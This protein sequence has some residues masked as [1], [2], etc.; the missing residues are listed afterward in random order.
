MPRILFEQIRRPQH[1]LSE[2]LQNADDAKAT[3]ASVDIKGDIFEFA[4]DGEDFTKEN[5]ESLCSFAYSSKSMLHTI[6]FRGVGFKSTFGLGDDV[7]IYTPS[8]SVRFNHER[9][10]EPEWVTSSPYADNLTH[11]R[12]ANIEQY[13]QKELEENL[14]EWSS[15]PVSLLFFRNIKALH[16]NGQKIQWR[17]L[18]NGPVPH[19]EWKTHEGNKV[20]V[21]RSEKMD[22]PPDVLDDIRK[23]RNISDFKNAAFPPCEVEVLLG[24]NKGHLYAILLAGI[25]SGLPFACN[26]PFIQTPDRSELKHPQESLTN[27]WLLERIGEL[28]AQ[29]ML[30]WLNK[31]D[32][33]LDERSGAYGL[34]PSTTQ[35]NNSAAGKCG[36]FIRDAFRKHTDGSN[37]LLVE[38]G[39]LAPGCIAVPEEILDAWAPEQASML[40]DKEQRPILYHK[41][42]PDDQKKILDSYAVDEIDRTKILQV[43]SEKKPPKPTIPDGIRTLWAYLGP[44]VPP[45]SRRKLNIVPVQGGKILHAA[46]EVVRIDEESPCSGDDWKFLSKHLRVM[47]KDWQLFLKEYSRSI[48]P[49]SAPVGNTGK[50]YDVLRLIC[51]DSASP[52]YKIMNGAA[53]R[54]SQSNA[55]LSDWVW[56]AQIAAKLKTRIDNIQFVTQDQKRRQA[57][58]ETILF[59]NG[60]ELESLLPT[61]QRLLRLLHRDYSKFTACSRKE[62][63]DWIES[64]HAGIRTFSK[65]E[66]NDE[67]VYGKHEIE[68]MALDRG[69]RANFS[70]PFKTEQFT[71]VDH[72]FD[73]A[74]WRHWERLA[75]DDGRVWFKIV[76]RMLASPAAYKN[77]I[78]ICQ[79][80]T[81]RKTEPV[82]VEKAIPPAWAMRLRK[83]R[84][85]P[86][87]R[88]ELRKPSELWTR[89]AENL[90]GGELFVDKDLDNENTRPLLELLGV[91]KAPTDPDSY[92]NRLRKLSESK[93]PP[94]PEAKE[95][96]KSLDQMLALPETEQHIM[97]AFHRESLVLDKDLNWRMVSAEIYLHQDESDPDALAIHPLISGLKMWGKMGMVDRPTADLAIEWVKSLQPRQFSTEEVQRIKKLLKKYPVRIWNECNHW[98]NLE[99]EWTPVKNLKYALTMHSLVP[100]RHL[101]AEIKRE[102]AYLQQLPKE[103]SENLPFSNLSRLDTKVEDRLDSDHVIVGKSVEKEWL[104]TI[105]AGLQL[106]N[107]DSAEDAE[108][109]HSLAKHLA[110]SK[111]QEVEQPLVVP[112]IDGRR[113]GKGRKVD[114]IW[115][116]KSDTIYVRR[117]PLSNLASL[118]PK[119]IGKVFDHRDIQYALH[120]G[121]ERSPQDIREYLES[122]FEL[123]DVVRPKM[124]PN[125][126]TDPVSNLVHSSPTGTGPRPPDRQ[127]DGPGYNESGAERKRVE[128]KGME[129]VMASEKKRVR[130]QKLG[131]KIEDV[132]SRKCGYDI[133]SPDRC[134]EVKSFKTTGSPSLTENEWNYAKNHGSECWLYIVENVFG[135]G[136]L[137]DKIIRIPDP[138][139]LPV[140]SVKT[141]TL[142]YKIRNWTDVRN[143]A[144]QH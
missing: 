14:K 106:V 128:L 124:N 126:G 107:L 11:I 96:Y 104:R 83:Y 137:E 51:L 47:D 39:S 31:Q 85:L 71:W 12:V 48:S 80:S 17:Y 35:G 105:G 123:S 2:L 121:F 74:H 98:L 56:F 27:R 44:D 117:L 140:D 73:E 114:V 67:Q 66:K 100:Y 36:D 23:E 16:I 33:S 21:V 81:T 4:H 30:A 20:L 18:R 37:M 59:D 82:S 102:T 7:E 55:G 19:S 3:E 57:N 90:G 94:I 38:D 58:K 68:Q 88:G 84:C 91:R 78:E 133:K 64:G 131:G 134:I 110:A 139:N 46:D 138:Q 24:I 76:K 141:V 109:I 70:Y 41:I 49:I 125:G 22:F 32:M 111:W 13:K 29:T 53:D 1:V 143:G 119:E 120:Y 5:F 42:K 54:L 6:G 142:T 10:T 43:L 28:A 115:E 86:D 129:L 79:K 77:R 113:A 101:F 34:L 60:G 118:V 9:F 99:G 97:Q 26:A 40:L 144:R 63:M 116:L 103:I 93:D 62:W 130:S 92:L 127:S 8:L 65:L 112:Y 69:I 15:N 95:M 108:H 72:N 87:A 50:A 135:K 136:Q 52:L 122:N 25:G 132:S 75:A 61:D 89:A 45:S